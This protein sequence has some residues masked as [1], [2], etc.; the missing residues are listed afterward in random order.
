MKYSGGY[1][2]NSKWGIS[3]STVIL[4]LSFGATNA[5]ATTIVNNEERTNSD[6]ERAVNVSK[7]TIDNQHSGTLKLLTNQNNVEASH[8]SIA[9]SSN[10]N[11]RIPNNTNVK[12]LIIAMIGNYHQQKKF[13]VVLQ[14]IM[15]N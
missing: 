12:L 6:N 15:K 13:Q 7:L 9:S 8:S 3:L 1:K 4:A 2:F 10:L 11:T 14:T 5:K